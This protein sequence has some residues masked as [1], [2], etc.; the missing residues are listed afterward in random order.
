M[1][2]DDEWRDP[3]E[4]ELPPV[5]SVPETSAAKDTEDATPAKEKAV[6][7]FSF[8]LSLIALLPTGML[9][10]LLALATWQLIFMESTCTF[11]AGVLGGSILAKIFIKRHISVLIHEAKHQIIS[12]LVGN[13][14][15][16]MKIEENSGHFEYSYSKKTTHYH[17]FIALAPY[18]LP[19]FT[20]VLA[21]IAFAVCREDHRIA[22]LVVGVGYGADLL[23]N[24]RD[25]SPIQTDINQIRGGYTIGLMYIA[26]WNFF[27]LGLILTWAFQGMTGFAMLLE[28][29][30]TLF[31]IVH[32]YLR[33]P[34]TG[35]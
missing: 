3:P 2:A 20:L 9:T 24:M 5:F 12:N 33:T 15:R 16:G 19:L 17:A 31:I 32:H 28:E 30:S 13:K 11:V 29:F 8:Y 27:I 10:L 26:A 18:I 1:A 35:D 7:S 23:L 21:L 6:G 22:A 14:S 25:I 4:P 34:V